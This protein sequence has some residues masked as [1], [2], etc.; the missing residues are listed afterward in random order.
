MYNLG[1]LNKLEVCEFVMI[2]YA[3]KFKEILTHP[4]V[5]ISTFTLGTVAVLTGSVTLG[6]YFGQYNNS[7]E[8]LVN[9]FIELQKAL[10]KI[11]LYNH[12]EKDT[13]ARMFIKSTTTHE[14]FADKISILIETYD[15]YSNISSINVCERIVG[16]GLHV[17]GDVL[18]ECGPYGLSGDAMQQLTS[19]HSTLE[20][21]SLNFGDIAKN[22]VEGQLSSAINGCV[23]TISAGVALL[24]IGGISMLVM[25]CH[26]N[27]TAKL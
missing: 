22:E 14:A 13:I 7:K 26:D 8:R 9:T 15:K 6:V 19:L 5:P 10:D 18:Q 27:R 24:I 17:A 12:I 4:A 20:I 1:I 2:D 16:R 3:Q 21:D 23:P 11:F 25:S